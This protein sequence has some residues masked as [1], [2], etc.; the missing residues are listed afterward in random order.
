[1]PTVSAAAMALVPAPQPAAQPATALPVLRPLLPR[2]ESYIEELRAIDER[3]WYSN[4]GPAVRRFEA[5][6]AAHFRLPPEGVASFSNGTIAL[7]VALQALGAQ[8]RQRCLMPSWTFVASA[9]AVVGAGLVPHFV[10]VDP[11][12]WALDPEALAKRHDLAGVGAVMAVS[13]FGAPLD[14]A[15]WETFTA[16]TGIPVLIDAAAGFD[17]VA[18]I[19]R[20]APGPTPMMVSLHATKVFGVGEGAI[21]L[22]SD[23][24]LV[25]LARQYGNFG[26]CSVAEAIVPG[27]NAKMSE[28]AAA[29][30]LATLREWPARRRQLLTAATTYRIALSRVPGVSLAPEFGNGWVGSTCCVTLPGDGLI[31]GERLA[32]RGIET[33]RWWRRGCHHQPAF[34]HYTR[35]KLPVT[36]DLARRCLGLPFYP[37]MTTEDIE[38]VAAALAACAD[39]D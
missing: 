32:E 36:L 35:D 39:T 9:S 13:P 7:T 19:G 12:T 5:L 23:R 27:T 3:R 20:A 6:L 34:A 31:A 24:P 30:G 11:N 33:R 25:E 14:R 2:A 8:P 18:S 4:H 21:L 22:S 15:R 26:F 37:D 16:K 38:R 29:V 10:D 17:A 28:Y 1:M